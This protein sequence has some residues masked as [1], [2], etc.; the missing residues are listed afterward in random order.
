M[1]HQ[2]KRPDLIITLSMDEQDGRDLYNERHLRCAGCGEGNPRVSMWVMPGLCVRCAIHVSG[3]RVAP[4][5]QSTFLVGK[6]AYPD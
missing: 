2:V 1:T 3:V 4:S 5:Q 6:S